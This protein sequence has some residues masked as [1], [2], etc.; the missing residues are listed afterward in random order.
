MIILIEIVVGCTITAFAATVWLANGYSPSC[1]LIS[2]DP[3][4]GTNRAKK[5]S[6]SISAPPRI[7]LAKSSAWVMNMIGKIWPG[8]F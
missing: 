5:L 2:V 3:G 8:K 4:S 6:R 7:P 1:W